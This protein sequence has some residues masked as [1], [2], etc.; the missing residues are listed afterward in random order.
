MKCKKPY[1][2]R[3]K[4][5]GFGESSGHGKTSTKGHKGQR[6]R[7][8]FTMRPTFEGGQT[9]LYRRVP[10][11]GFN[12]PAHKEYAIVNLDQIEAL[13]VAEIKPEWLIENE[14]VKKLGAGLKI[15]GRGKL[16]KGITVHAHKFSAQA[17]EAIEKAGGRAMVI[18][19][20]K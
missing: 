4:R 17:K 3:K 20:K 9:P 8:G 18:A 19:Q 16:T 15:L 13:G 1:K 14:V 12:R 11:R 10:V 2:K 7:S 6:A 5:I